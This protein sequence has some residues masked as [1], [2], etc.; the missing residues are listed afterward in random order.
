MASKLTELRLNLRIGLESPGETPYRIAIFDW[1]MIA[2]ALFAT[3]G[4]DS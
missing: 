4:S 1:R 3:T 2:A